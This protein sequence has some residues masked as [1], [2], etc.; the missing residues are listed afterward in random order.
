MKY[1]IA[2]IL[3]FVSLSISFSMP[4]IAAPSK[5]S[6]TLS[7]S[8]SSMPN[9]TRFDVSNLDKSDG[10]PPRGRTQHLNIISFRLKDS[11][12]LSMAKKVIADCPKIGMVRFVSNGSDEQS[13][14]GL[15]NGKVQ[16]FKCVGMES[17]NKWGEYA[18]S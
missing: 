10:I 11:K 1:L 9:I 14:Y 4:V 3:P 8:K 15:L 7:K 18:C 5:C 13:V 2:A 6:T 16:L 17:T 12:E